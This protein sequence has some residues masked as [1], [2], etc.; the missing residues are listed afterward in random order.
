MKTSERLVRIS[1]T[2]GIITIISLLFSVLALMDIYQNNEP[3]LNMEWTIVKTNLLITLLF[4]IISSIT[5]I[6]IRKK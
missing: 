6:R 2:L 4:V 1:L 3:N 5:T